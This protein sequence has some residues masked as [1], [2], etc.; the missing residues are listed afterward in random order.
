MAKKDWLTGQSL[1]RQGTNPIAGFLAGMMQAQSQ[2]QAQ[3]DAQ[4]REQQK[5]AMMQIQEGRTLLEKAAQ[6]DPNLWGSQDFVGAWKTGS[7][8]YLAQSGWKPKTPEET[9][10]LKDQF[11]E[12]VS[13]YYT[14][15]PT[16]KTWP[17]PIKNY[18]TKSLGLF[19]PQEKPTMMNVG[20]G[21]VIFDPVTRKPIFKNPHTYKPDTSPNPKSDGLSE[22]EKILVQYFDPKK[23]E[24]H[25][26]E[27]DKDPLWPA[28]QK[29]QKKLGWLGEDTG[30]PTITRST[31]DN[32]IAQGYKKEDILAKYT[33]Q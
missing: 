9:K 30:K 16:G 15:D 3:E 11:D 1:E 31:Y 26:D 19:A 27:R 7:V 33:V 4:R 13:Q 6:M 28:Y 29:L 22:Q 2:K 23:W 20:E 14:Q 5:Q 10:T 12:Q 25:M 32:L 17:E 18:A 21:G 24:M 8:D